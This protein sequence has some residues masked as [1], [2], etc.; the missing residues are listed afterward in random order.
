VLPSGYLYAQDAE[1]AGAIY[2]SRGYFSGTMAIGAGDPWSA[3]ATYSI[4]DKVVYNGYTY[5][6]IENSSNTLPTDT[7]KWRS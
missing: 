4:G 7:T 6:A 3:E 2:A 5:E 1:I